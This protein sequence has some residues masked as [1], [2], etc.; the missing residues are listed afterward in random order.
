[1]RVNGTEGEI[2]DLG[3]VRLRGALSIRGTVL[4]PDGK[5]PTRG[6]VMH[7]G[8]GRSHDLEPDGSFELGSLEPGRHTIKA[9]VF[10]DGDDAWSRGL[11]ATVTDVEAGATDVLIRVT[12]GGNLIVRFHPL[13]KPAKPLEVNGASI[14]WGHRGGGG[15]DK[16]TEM[17]MTFEPGRRT[18]VRIEAEGYK[19]R[20]LGP[21]V[22][23]ADRPTV[24]DVELEPAR[25]RGGKSSC[26]L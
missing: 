6:H 5:P 7:D 23:H 18:D 26:G 14:C 24:V 3:T 11:E 9:T 10:E 16:R 22:I 13:G 2:V 4:G 15:G 20:F 21:I 1:M 25:H 19:T 8:P 12:G 17:R